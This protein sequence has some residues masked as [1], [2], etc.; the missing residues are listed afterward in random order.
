MVRVDAFQLLLML[1]VGSAKKCSKTCS[2]HVFD[3]GGG[4]PATLGMSCSASLGSSGHCMCGDG[5]TCA[6]DSSI[7]IETKAP[8]PND[9]KQTNCTPTLTNW[10]G[11]CPNGQ[12][13]SA[14]FP[15]QGICQCSVGTTCTSGG[16]CQAYKVPEARDCISSCT[17]TVFNPGGG[18]KYGQS[19]STTVGTGVCQ[20]GV[21][22]TCSS[23]SSVC[24]V[25][26][27]PEPRNCNHTT[28]TPTLTDWAGGCKNS[29][30]C[31][32]GGVG[33]Q[34]ICQCPVSTKCTSKGT[35]ESTKT[36]EL[37]DCHTTC[38]VNVFS[39]L[40]GCKLGQTCSANVGVGVCQCPTGQ[41]CSAD[42]ATCSVVSD[43]KPHDCSTKCKPDLI[44]W[45]GG[46][47]LGQTCSNVWPHAGHCYC[48]SEQ[49]TCSADGLSCT[50]P[51]AQTSRLWEKVKVQ[52][53][54][55]M[56]LAPPIVLVPAGLVA[57]V[58]MSMAVRKYHQRPRV[59]VARLLPTDVEITEIEMP[60]ATAE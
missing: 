34:G 7:C 51:T 58:M 31:S 20:C 29:Q 5:E 46:C 15:R 14:R 22:Q 2:P 40:G 47:Q 33:L 54:N 57:A 56:S 36:P 25:V 38:S 4:C 28:C 41:H 44:N 59:C 6:S 42:G 35:C 45:N 43:N 17:A 53:S 13:C 37:E 32:S 1:A 55:L 16:V 9:C 10:A 27:A 39:P 12:T 23:D 30:T 26:P 24:Q 3:W 49:D 11:G 60:G 50:P 19:C 52:A 8:E 18:C 48:N 21:G